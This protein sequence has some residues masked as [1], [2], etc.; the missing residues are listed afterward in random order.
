MLPMYLKNILGWIIV[1]SYL[2]GLL[3]KM[4]IFKQMKNF[5]ISERPINVLI[6]IDEL[7]YLTLITFMALNLGIVL[8]G[9]Q[10]PYQFFSTFFGMEIDESVSVLWDLFDFQKQTKCNKS[11]CFVKDFKI[12]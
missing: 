1:F 11:V 8:I 5:K 6:L 2:I 4:I 12:K 10:T 3:G 9:Q 7:I